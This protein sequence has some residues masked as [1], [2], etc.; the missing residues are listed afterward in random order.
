MKMCDPKVK[1][2]LKKVNKPVFGED[3]PIKYNPNFTSNAIRVNL[4][5]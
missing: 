4:I 2:L 1:L 3:E 5:P